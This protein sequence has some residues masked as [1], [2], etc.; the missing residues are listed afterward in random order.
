MPD[1]PIADP[2][3]DTDDSATPDETVPAADPAPQGAVFTQEQVNE[4][5][6]KARAEGKRSARKQKPTPQTPAQA[7]APDIAEVLAAALGPQQEQLEKLTSYMVSQQTQQL[8]AA[9]DSAFKASGV[10]ESMRPF[11]LDSYRAQ[12]PANAIEWM[13][14]AAKAFDATA[15][16]KAQE[17][18]TPG[19][20]PTPGSRNPETINVAELTAADVRRLQ[21]EGRFHE[22]LERARLQ[23][24]NGAPMPFS[25]R[26]LPK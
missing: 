12:S 7:P 15:A 24:N 16:P 18:A 9:F 8:E 4:L 25:K 20:L 3:P 17:V 26:P 5:M 10:P 22:V 21:G 19:S 23:G 2:T 11:M 1:E 13:A 14:N 6:A